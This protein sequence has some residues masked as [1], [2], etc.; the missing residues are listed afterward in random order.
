M[1]KTLFL[2]AAVVLC[3]VLLVGFV[4]FPVSGVSETDSNTTPARTTFPSPTP[5]PAKPMPSMP[6]PS[7]PVSLAPVR[8]DSA[9]T[10]SLPKPTPL[11]SDP[12]YLPVGRDEVRT[13]FRFVT[14][15][16]DNV[17][18]VILEEVTGTGLRLELNSDGDPNDTWFTGSI[19]I[20]T[21]GLKPDQCLEFVTVLNGVNR[22]RPYKLAATGLPVGF[23]GL[24]ARDHVIDPDTREKVLRELLMTFG[25]NV[26]EKRIQAIVAGVGGTVVG[27][28]PLDKPFFQ[29]R[30]DR[31]VTFAQLRSI[32][33][34][35]KALPEVN[36]AG[37]QRASVYPHADAAV[38][39]DP[40]AR[41]QK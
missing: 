20:D 25:D 38:P 41:P 5:A 23:A 28:I 24:D 9:D 26:K 27:R 22:Y 3:G 21:S 33:E 17:S 16:L 31:P 13:T 34:R 39:S 29:V 37:L 35:L 15:G 11:S 10:A 1:N 18:S 6:A 8:A 32:A 2:V 4:L 30:F 12:K 14:R 19:T 7:V 36:H 40:K